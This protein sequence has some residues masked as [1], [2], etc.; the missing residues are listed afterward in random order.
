MILQI[1]DL[2]SVPKRVKRK[3]PQETFTLKQHLGPPSGP[4]GSSSGG[5]LYGLGC[6]CIRGSAPSSPSLRKWKKSVN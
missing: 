3:G 6:S 1:E 4:G 2:K 5:S